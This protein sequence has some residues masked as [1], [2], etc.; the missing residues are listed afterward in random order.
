M[1]KWIP[2]HIVIQHTIMM[3]KKERKN[4]VKMAV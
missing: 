3:A 1:T 2:H 4:K